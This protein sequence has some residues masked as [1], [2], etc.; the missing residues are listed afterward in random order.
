MCMHA[1]LCLTLGYLMDCSQAPLSMGFIRSEYWSGL[2]LPF[3][4]NQYEGTSVK[5]KNSDKIVC[6]KREDL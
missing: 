3:A 2:P 5:S 1:Q 6:P 4:M